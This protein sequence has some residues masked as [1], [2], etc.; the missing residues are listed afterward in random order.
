MMPKTIHRKGQERIESRVYL[1][2]KVIHVDAVPAEIRRTLPHEFRNSYSR[3]NPTN[4]LICDL[5]SK[6]VRN[7]IHLF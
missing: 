5:C 1:R 2:R 7:P 4:M 6:R 3:K